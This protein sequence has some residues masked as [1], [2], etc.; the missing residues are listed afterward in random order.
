MEQTKHLILN[1]KTTELKEIYISDTASGLEQEVVQSTA[2][3]LPWIQ[4]APDAPY[5]VTDEGENWTPIGQNDAITWPDFANAFRRKDLKQVEGHLAWLASHGVTC[6][7]FM[8]EYAQ[9]ENR[10]FERPTGTFSPNMVRLWDNLFELCGKYKIRI[11][12]TP[13][14]TFWMWIRWK[15]HPY[16]KQNGGPC[17]HR[18]QWLLCANT[19]KAIKN[20]LT[21]VTERWGGSGVLFAWDLWNEIHPAH[22]NNRTEVFHSFIK[23]VSEHLRETE[24]RL[25]GRSHPQTVSLYGPVLD[26]NPEVADAIFRHPNLDFASTHFYDAATINNPKDTLWSAIVTGRLVRE[27]LEHLNKS[28]PF[29]DSE[30]G[31]IHAFKDRKKTLPE[32]FDDEY[33][34]HMQW[35]HFASG[36]AGGGMR[37]PN[38]HPH[39]LTHGMRCAQKSLAAFT[40][41]IDWKRFKRKNLN[42]EV[43]TNSTAVTVFACADQEQAVVWVL[44]TDTV[45]KREGKLNP[46]AR[47]LEVGLK[48]P[49]MEKGKYLFTIW[50]TAEGK[51]I[52]QEEAQ[53]LVSGSLS[54]VIPAVVTDVALA[55]RKIG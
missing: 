17:S 3:D 31:P 5:F 27:A 37:W 39:T 18:S 45:R 11:L 23:E 42:Y 55:I 53:N 50:N 13:V 26:E 8:L 32:P 12:L 25:H 2:N 54:V 24:M 49:G 34:R 38:R 1:T 9:T 22:A 48:V 21:F 51:T 19:R 10:Y 7:R 41:L 33:F 40:S 52:L 16:N 35:A 47:P 20:R 46:A 4:V 15:H 30:H 28:R 14:D 6:L 43:Q 29:F 44:R 36:G